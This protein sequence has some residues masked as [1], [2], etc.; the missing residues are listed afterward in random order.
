[1]SHKNF[2]GQWGYG[3]L[4]LLERIQDKLAVTE[5]ITIVF[6]HAEVW[7]ALCVIRAQQLLDKVGWSIEAL[8]LIFQRW[9]DVVCTWLGKLAA[10][11]RKYAAFPVRARCFGKR[12][13]HSRSKETR[14][15]LALPCALQLLNVLLSTNL[16]QWLGAALPT[17]AGCMFL[18]R[19]KTQ[20]FKAARGI[21]TCIWRGMDEQSQAG[22]AQSN[23]ASFYD[24]LPMLR[25][26]RWLLSKNYC[27][28][29]ARAVLG[30]QMAPV[31]WVS[32]RD[33]SLSI[34]KRSNGG[35]IGSRTAGA[36][37]RIQVQEVMSR[38]P[39][40]WKRWGFWAGCQCLTLRAYVDNVSLRP[41]PLQRHRHA[42]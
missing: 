21:Q 22:A 36:C 3:A 4:Q 42:G 8:Q 11:S 26:F 41:Q 6:T 13:S 20:A 19:P 25:S 31:V 33:V 28:L 27:P 40:H 7:H 29:R 12:S 34:D 2:N 24:S 10:C 16:Q 17:P 37:G 32:F 14:A 30:H 1:V 5:G 18:G 35:L 38:R 23:A 9:P 15:I 39:Q